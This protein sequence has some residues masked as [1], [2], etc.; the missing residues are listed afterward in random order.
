MVVDLY[1]KEKGKKPSL[2]LCFR[3]LVS[4]RHASTGC[5]QGLFPHVFSV[6]LPPVSVTRHVPPRAPG[7]PEPAPEAARAARES[8]LCN[9]CGQG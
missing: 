8:P 4:R 5:L 7:S 9:S 3:S 2:A 6:P 1:V